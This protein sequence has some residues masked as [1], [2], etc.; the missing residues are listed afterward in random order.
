[1]SFD[2]YDL[3]LYLQYFRKQYKQHDNAK[4]LLRPGRSKKIRQNI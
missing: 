4:N 2:N 1:M 3:K